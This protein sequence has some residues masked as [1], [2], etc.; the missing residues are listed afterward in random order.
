MGWFI[1]GLTTSTIVRLRHEQ[2]QIKREKSSYSNLNR[3]IQLLFDHHC[4]TYTAILEL[5]KIVYGYEAGAID[6]N[7]FNI[8]AQMLMVV[9]YYT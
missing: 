4:E 8:H 3:F 6:T 1:I 5:G 9:T 2:Q 7:I